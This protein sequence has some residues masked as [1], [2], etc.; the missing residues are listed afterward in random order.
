LLVLLSFERFLRIILGAEAT[1]RDTLP[2]LLEKATSQSRNLLWIPGQWTRQD[3]IKAI[4]GVRNTLMHGNYEQAAT[5]AHQ[6]DVRSYFT[7]GNYISEVET[8]FHL[9]DDF[10]YK[11]T[12]TTE[13]PHPSGRSRI[14]AETLAPPANRGSFTVPLIA[15]Q[16]IPSSPP[17]PGVGVNGR[18]THG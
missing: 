15:P 8:L 13:K 1:D 11:D 17:P 9:L 14:H 4:V 10:F 2:N 12:A 3:A 6:A 7:S 5:G 18:R 16:T